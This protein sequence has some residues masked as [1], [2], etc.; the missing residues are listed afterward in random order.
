MQL[1]DLVWLK[2]AD[3]RGQWGIGIIINIHASTYEN[4]A[5]VVSVYWPKVNRKTWNH[6]IAY[7]E[8]IHEAG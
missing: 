4:H 2:D 3:Q 7:I 1:T 5:T 8:V 6:T